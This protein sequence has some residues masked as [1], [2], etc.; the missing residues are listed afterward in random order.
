LLLDHVAASLF[1]IHVVVNVK[2]WIDVTLRLRPQS[3]AGK[4]AQYSQAFAAGMHARYAGVFS[5]RLESCAL[6]SRACLQ[7]QWRFMPGKGSIL[8]GN[9][10]QRVAPA[11]FDRRDERRR[12]HVA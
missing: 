9:A 3:T 5:I 4:R 10:D 1:D 12:R 6:N 8:T 2:D 11:Q 7:L